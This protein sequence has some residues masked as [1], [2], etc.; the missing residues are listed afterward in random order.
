[1]AYRRE[2]QQSIKFAMACRLE[3]QRSA[4]ARRGA[5]L[6]YHRVAEV[7][8]DPWRM[9]VSAENFAAH[10]AALR[11]RRLARPL[12]KLAGQLQAPG[13]PDNAVAVTFDDGYLDNLR[14]ALPIL[15]HQQVP[16]TIYIV[17]GAVG[18]P[19]AFWWDLVSKVFLET[20]TLPE[21]LT[22]SQ[23]EASQQW[24]LGPSA[25][26][27]PAALTHLAGW[28]ADLEPAR[29]RRQKAFLDVWAFIAAL[30]PA[31]RQRAIAELAEWS[32][33][34]PVPSEG[35]GVRPVD[36]PELEQMALSPLI[37]IGGHTMTH[38]DLG[39]VGSGRAEE[40]ISDCRHMLREAT[41]Q[42]ITSF[43]YPF[44]RYS[45]ETVRL[46]DAAGFKNATCSK[47]GIATG[48][49][50]ALELPRVQ[51]PN[52]S[53]KSFEKMLDALFGK[54]ITLGLPAAT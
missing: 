33:I 44:G 41:G 22:L 21:T 19:D 13:A 5:I 12:S 37:E 25:S 49:S 52:I 3:R 24:Q 20:A 11:R 8:A 51:V 26:L 31:A 47:F 46:I 35:S 29:D 30:E 32:G 16:A 10:M 18:K 2:R 53:G 36:F 15:E 43:A 1:M 4:G 42:N 7:G 45:P 34:S 28:K 6:L 48:R 17:G 40:E 38:A 27:S 23:G 50:P 54:D 9:V 14:T 39:Q